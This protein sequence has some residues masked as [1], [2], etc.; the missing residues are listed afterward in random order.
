VKA[1]FDTSV[2]VAALVANHPRHERAIR[3]VRAAA[4][5]DIEAQC[6]WHAV[7]E[8]W[9]VLTRLPITPAITPE[10]A[11]IAVERLT[12]H[13][14]PIQLGEVEYRGAIARCAERGLRSGA[15]FDALHLIA[16]EQSRADLLL[17]FN[18]SDFTRLAGAAGPRVVVPPDPPRLLGPHD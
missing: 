10:L 11:R 4:E 18:A 1:A 7:A 2:L 5:R 14:T 3:W 9:S 13:V 16:A 15:V 17:T 12:R 6:S 8:T